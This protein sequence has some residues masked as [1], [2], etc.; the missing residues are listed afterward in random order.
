MIIQRNWLLA[1]LAF[2][3]LC[4]PAQMMFGQLDQGTITGIVQDPSGAV[5]ACCRDTNQC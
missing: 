5:I 2:E 4:M 1:L 3:L